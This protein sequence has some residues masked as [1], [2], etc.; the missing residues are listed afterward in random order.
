MDKP[1]HLVR[2]TVRGGVPPPCPALRAANSTPLGKG[3]A[4]PPAQSAGSPLPRLWRCYQ[5]E[6]DKAWAEWASACTRTGQEQP[7]GHPAPKNSQRQYSYQEG[8]L[9]VHRAPMLFDELH[10]H[11]R[12]ASHRADPLPSPSLKSADQ[13]PPRP[14]EGHQAEQSGSACLMVSLFTH[15][16]GDARRPR[17][18]SC[19]A[20]RPR[21]FPAVRYFGG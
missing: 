13:E 4:L 5:K 16:T 6:G 21:L 3:Y 18:P 17:Q 11:E 19:E 20:D 7:E 1:P 8:R 2:L 12:R 15:Q 10:R 14:D 9:P